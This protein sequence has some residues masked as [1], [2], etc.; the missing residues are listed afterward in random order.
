MAF[1]EYSLEVL[2]KE[3]SKT[4]VLKFFQ[5]KFDRIHHLRGNWIENATNCQLRYDFLSCEEFD[6]IFSRN[7]PFFENLVKI[8]AANNINLEKLKKQA[9]SCLKPPN[10]KDQIVLKI[11]TNRK[12]PIRKNY[13]FTFNFSEIA[14]LHVQ[15]E[16]IADGFLVFYHNLNDFKKMQDNKL[17]RKNLSQWFEKMSAINFSADLVEDI[18]D[19]L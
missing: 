5:E 17:D 12:E 3:F 11:A 15:Y 2:P 14:G 7:I 8:F 9:L 18:L 6:R 19:Q 1:L 13:A 4:E 16:E 10:V